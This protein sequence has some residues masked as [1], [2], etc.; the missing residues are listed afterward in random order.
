MKTAAPKAVRPT[1]RRTLRALGGRSILV[2]GFGRRSPAFVS[3]AGGSD[4]PVGAWISPAELRRF[5]A[6][7]RRI[8]R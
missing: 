3:I 1:T 2:E 5:V 6:A 7:A 8:L 4:V